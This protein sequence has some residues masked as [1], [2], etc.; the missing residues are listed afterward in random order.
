MEKKRTFIVSG[1]HC[2]G[3]AAAVERLMKNFPVRE[4]YVNFASGRLNFVSDENIPSDD[5]IIAA[6]KKAGFRAELPPAGLTLPTEISSVGE[7]WSFIVAAFF[8]VALMIVCMG[9]IPADPYGQYLFCHAGRHS[10]QGKS[11]D[12]LCAGFGI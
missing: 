6:V 2:A 10:A 7:V 4:V 3:C 9:N 12:L 11:A 8:A 1:M 5:E